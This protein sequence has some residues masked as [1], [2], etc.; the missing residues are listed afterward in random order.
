M[1]FVKAMR[2]KL[3]DHTTCKHWEIIPW[4]RMPSNMKMSMAIWSFKG[5]IYQMAH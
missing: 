2:K 3:D 5:N 4:L 1:E